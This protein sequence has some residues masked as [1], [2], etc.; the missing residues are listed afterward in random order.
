MV[1][2]FF[3]SIENVY[4]AHDY[5][6]LGWRIIAI[7]GIRKHMVSGNHNEMFLSPGVEKVVSILQEVLDSEDSESYE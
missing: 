5:K 6:Y 2:D 7:G 1:F 3:R 4:F